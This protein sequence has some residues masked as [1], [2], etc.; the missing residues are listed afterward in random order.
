MTAQ[1]SKFWYYQ[2]GTSMW[3]TQVNADGT[4]IRQ[5]GSWEAKSDMSMG[6]VFVTGEFSA[7]SI[8]HRLLAGL[9]LANK[10][11]FADWGQKHALDTETQK[12]NVNN[13]NLGAPP[14][15]YPRFD[16]TAPLEERAQKINGLMD[17]R[18]NGIYLQDELSAFENKVR[19]TLAGRYTYVKQSQYGG[20]PKSADH[21]TPRLGL[22][23]SLDKNT[24][25][26]ALYDQAF[27]PQSGRLSNGRAV[28]PLTGENRE[29]GI[30]RD[31]V[32]GQW[33][34][35]LSYYR[36]VKK[37]ELIADPNAPANSGLS[38]ELGEKK[39]EGIEF[40]IKGAI[41]RGLTLSAN[42]AYTDS[43]ISKL[44]QGIVSLKEGDILP[45]YASH[46][47]NAWVNYKLNRG[48]LKGAGASLGATYLGKRQ[49]FW[50]KSPDPN[51]TLP[52]YF[53]LDGGLFWEKNHLKITANVFNVL[54][55]YL[56]GGSYYSWLNA[57]YWQADPPRNIRL[58]IA[59]SF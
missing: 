54:D 56:Y 34:T 37:H 51:Q 41:V 46:T 20:E 26:Y 29:I 27:T 14:N 39:S 47:A 7:A 5:A 23:Y 40:D 19:L 16:F 33:N 15:G 36:I 31:W 10:N 59:Y 55:T 3:P 8:H 48:R 49:T 43:R 45:G 50:S 44:A 53:K 57:Y 28:K 11:Y 18:Y 32:G 6:Q 30:K 52:N 4:M 42:Y 2:Q 9:D 13:P 38:I 58:S 21:F 24:T 1:V 17:Q 12:F 25:A 35:A 22:S